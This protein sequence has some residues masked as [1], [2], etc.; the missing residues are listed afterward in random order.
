[1]TIFKSTNIDL[2]E[3]SFPPAKIAKSPVTS[4]IFF[5]DA[6]TS[7][8]GKSQLKNKTAISAMPPKVPA[9]LSKKSNSYDNTNK[10]SYP[11]YQIKEDTQP[12]SSRY[13]GLP[14]KPEEV[15][16]QKYEQLMAQTFIP[17]LSILEK[18]IT[19]LS[20]LPEAL[21]H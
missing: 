13:K 6:D 2:L 20:N 8:L 15:V 18:R 4:K 9:T 17:E 3:R 21:R 19:E 7:K 5:L 11:K 1:M 16:S 14:P 12:L 10:K